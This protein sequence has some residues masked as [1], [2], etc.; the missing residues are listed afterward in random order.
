[1]GVA[2]MLCIFRVVLEGKTDKEMMMMMTCIIKISFLRKVFSQQFFSIKCRRKHFFSI[3][4]CLSARGGD[5][6]HSHILKRMDRK[7]GGGGQKKMYA[8]V[9][10]VCMAEFLS[11]IYLGVYYVSLLCK[12]KYGFEAQ[13]QMLILALR[14]AL[15]I[16]STPNFNLAQVLAQDFLQK[17]MLLKITTPLEDVR[18]CYV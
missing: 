1:M 5:N 12:T 16:N 2:G 18:I 17:K 7:G 13:F 3:S 10:W 4:D 11:H 6:F 9:T 8:W 15:F 14:L